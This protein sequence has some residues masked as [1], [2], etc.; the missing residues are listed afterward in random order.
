MLQAH[1]FQDAVAQVSNLP[2]A[3]SENDIK[4]SQAQ[5]HRES[6]AP[7][8]LR[9]RETHRA[10]SSPRKQYHGPSVNTI[11]AA[12]RVAGGEAAGGQVALIC[13]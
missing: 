11:E 1:E 7:S 8:R 2:V 10:A 13:T 5:I 3:L 6:P 9:A 12:G 4:R